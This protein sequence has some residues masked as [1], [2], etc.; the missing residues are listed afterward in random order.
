MVDVERGVVC[1]V[2]GWGRCWGSCEKRGQLLPG[3]VAE[4]DSSEALQNSAANFSV[5]RYHWSTFHT[6]QQKGPWEEG[7]ENISRQK[8]RKD[9]GNTHNSRGTCI[10]QRTFL[11]KTLWVTA[12]VASLSRSSIDRPYTEIRSSA[13][14]YLLSTM[15]DITSCSEI[16]CTVARAY[17]FLWLHEDTNFMVGW[18]TL[19]MCLLL[20]VMYMWRTHDVHMCLMAMTLW[21]AIART[22]YPTTSPRQLGGK[23]MRT[24]KQ[25]VFQRRY[26]HVWGV[27]LTLCIAKYCGL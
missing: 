18:I 1:L 15:S 17:I 24:S 26:I 25:W 14:W 3:R 8:R 5:C 19:P 2:P 10:T 13:I 9:E 7:E 23:Y 6:P 11:Q 12:H 20:H 27:P 22:T 4:T 16:W 21:D